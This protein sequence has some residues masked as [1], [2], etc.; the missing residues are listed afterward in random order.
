MRHPCIFT[1]WTKARMPSEH[2]E[3]LLK[4]CALFYA[5]MM[6]WIMPYEMHLTQIWYGSWLPTYCKIFPV[7]R[8]DCTAATAIGN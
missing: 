6:R 5:I 2:L 7:G 4:G 1:V 8:Q 3:N